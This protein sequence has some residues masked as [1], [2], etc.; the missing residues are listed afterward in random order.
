[1]IISCRFA[2]NAP[3]IFISFHQRLVT[4]PVAVDSCLIDQISSPHVSVRG[5][6]ANNCTARILAKKQRYEFYLCIYGGFTEVWP[7]IIYLFWCIVCAF[8]KE[9]LVTMSL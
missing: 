1:M 6:T 7:S 2:C 5:Y 4:H 8:A 9:L 3:G